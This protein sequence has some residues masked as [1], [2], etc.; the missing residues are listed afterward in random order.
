MERSKQIRRSTL[1]ATS[2]FAEADSVSQQ[3]YFPDLNT[4]TKSVSRFSRDNYTLAL[5]INNPPGVYGEK[6]TDEEG[7]HTEAKKTERRLNRD[8]FSCFQEFREFRELLL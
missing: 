8:L 1:P 2:S 7:K 3:G 4:L 6:K 5:P